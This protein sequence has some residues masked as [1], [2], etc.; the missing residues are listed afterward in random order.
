M[1]E[2]VENPSIPKKLGANA[3]R[4]VEERYEQKGVWDAYLREYQKLLRENHQ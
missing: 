3:R 1:C 2:W 4:L